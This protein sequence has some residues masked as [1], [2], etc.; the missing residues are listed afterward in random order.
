MLDAVKQY[1]GIDFADDDNLLQSFIDAAY[2]FLDGAI[3]NSYDRS[4]PRAQLLLKAI[5]YDWYENRG[6]SSQEKLSAGTQRM[7]D[8]CIQQMRLEREP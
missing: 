6:S 7:L 2:A 8:T 3:Y 4:D 1:I 5:V